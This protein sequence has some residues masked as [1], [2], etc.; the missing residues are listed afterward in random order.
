LPILAIALL[1]WL[2]LAI[3]LFG[4]A[5]GTRALIMSGLLHAGT[6]TPLAPL[7]FSAPSAGCCSA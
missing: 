6:A 7:V 2:A 5:T 1:M 3:G 4:W